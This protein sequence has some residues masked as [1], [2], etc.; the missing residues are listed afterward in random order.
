[1]TVEA[2][3]SIQGAAGRQIK[4]LKQ[5]KFDGLIVKVHLQLV[6]ILREGLINLVSP[7]MNLSWW[8]LVSFYFK[9]TFGFDH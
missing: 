2:T 1:M 8:C 3:L 9:N 7:Q 6:F 4:A 5:L